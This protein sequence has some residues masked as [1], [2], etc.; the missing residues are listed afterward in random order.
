MPIM[1]IFVLLVIALIVISGLSSGRQLQA[2]G[3]V[4]SAQQQ[5]GTIVSHIQ[6]LYANNVDYSNL[7]NTVACT[8]NVFP[9]GCS[10]G[11]NVT[12]SLG[13]AVS[14]W[15]DA[16]P[17]PDFNVSLLAP[18]N[19]LCIQAATSIPAWQVYVWNQSSPS[20]VLLNPAGGAVS[21]TVAQQ[22]CT[23]G[24]NNVVDFKFLKTSQ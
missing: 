10:G 13:G 7:S 3:A 17:P 4:S 14:V 12:S 2:S 18:S 19:A 15:P 16:G 1:M 24:S 11:Q 23:F 9:Q 20:P 22:N 6:S 5:V 21:P 8:A